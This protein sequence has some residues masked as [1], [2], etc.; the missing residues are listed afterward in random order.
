MARLAHAGHVSGPSAWLASRKNTPTGLEQAHAVG[1]ARQVVLAG[2]R[3][4]C[5]AASCASPT[6]GAA[7]GI[8]HTNRIGIAGQF[9]LPTLF[10]EAEVDGLLVAQLRQQL[11][12]QAGSRGVGSR[13]ARGA[14]RG[15]A[16]RASSR[17]C[18]PS[19][20]MTSSIRSSSIRMS[21][22]K[23]G[24][25]TVSSSPALTLEGQTEALKTCSHSACVTAM[26]STL[27]GAC[28]AQA[29]PAADSGKRKHLVVERASLAATDVEHQLTVMRS[30]CS[31]I[32]AGIHTPLEAVGG[33][34]A[35]VVAA[36]A[37]PC[38]ASGHQ[39]AASM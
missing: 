25:V 27:A 20:R 39:K 36:R 23:L 19:T 24:G 4:S 31:A 21:W 18:R 32:D 6:S 29:A 33:V 17:R 13:A 11:T 2:C 16:A 26:P 38:T 37:L 1:A 15:R 34:G 5:P 22:R 12:T 9:S 3:S 10:D 7:I 8:E 30:M 14:P 28:H 35:E